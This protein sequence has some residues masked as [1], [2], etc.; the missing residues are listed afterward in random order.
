[1]SSAYHLATELAQVRPV[2][3]GWRKQGLS[4]AL[5]P[6]MGALHA[7]HLAL[8]TQ[9]QQNHQ[10]IVVSIFVNPL[11]FGPG[12]D[13]TRYPRDT[14]R[15]LDLCQKAGVDM[16]WL[17]HHGHIYPPDFQTRL[18]A[19][20]LAEPLCGAK[21]PGHFDGVVTIVAKLFLQITPDGAFFGEKDYQQLLIIRQLVK[22]LDF[23]VTIHPVP[24]QRAEDGLALSSRN[25][26]LDS[27]QRPQ[28]ARLYRILQDCAAEILV[29][30]YN[31]PSILTRYQAALRQSGFD[32]CEYLTLCHAHSLE[33]LTEF[34]PP[35]RLFAAVY[36][37]ETRLID[38]LAL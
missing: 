25:K 37:G 8:I 21:R 15:D 38:N 9:A 31:V 5:V 16:V 3:Q 32:R 34:V 36:M 17:P 19:G 24:I 14:K 1:M 20:K 33:E 2:I 11:Q 12:E 26:Y 29:D 18:Q 22:D 7:G 23:P 27:T 30:S 10:R 35:A 6:T 4:I 13:F 28:A